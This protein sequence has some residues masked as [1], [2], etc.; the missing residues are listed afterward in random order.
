MSEMTN[1]DRRQRLAG[2][3]LGGD[4]LMRAQ[5]RTLIGSILDRIDWDKQMS[6]TSEN[7]G[8]EVSEIYHPSPNYNN[9]VTNRI[10]S[11]LSY[12]YY[13]VLAVIPVIILIIYQWLK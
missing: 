8:E 6:I 1:T 7:Y 5:F 4:G 13:G 2:V 11:T 12:Y 3:R 9:Q 10:S